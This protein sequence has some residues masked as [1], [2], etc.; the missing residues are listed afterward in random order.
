MEQPPKCC[1][2][3]MNLIETTEI[4][5]E[6]NQVKNKWKEVDTSHYMQYRCTKCDKEEIITFS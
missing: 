6:Y 4:I 2:D 3:S 5:N 1:G